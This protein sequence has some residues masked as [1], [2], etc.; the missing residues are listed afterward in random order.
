MNDLFIFLLHATVCS[1]LQTE[2]SL[3]FH[4]IQSPGQDLVLPS[5]IRTPVD[6]GDPVGLALKTHFTPP[7]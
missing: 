7:Y 2:T 1:A 6:S 4:W 5:C 3:W